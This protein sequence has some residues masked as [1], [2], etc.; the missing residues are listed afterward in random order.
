MYPPGTTRGLLSH[1]FACLSSEHVHMPVVATVM[2]IAD[3]LLSKSS[4]EFDSKELN[5]LID[6][7]SEIR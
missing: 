3:N 2:E 1:V 7:G 4:V 5:D 6:Y